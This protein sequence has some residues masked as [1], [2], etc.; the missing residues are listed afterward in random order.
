MEEKKQQEEKKRTRTPSKKK[1]YIGYQ[2]C[3]KNTQLFGYTIIESSGIP[4]LEDVQKGIETA[5]KTANVVIV[6]CFET[7]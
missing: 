7:K 6:S 1:Y 5:R 4:N 3:P 2:Y